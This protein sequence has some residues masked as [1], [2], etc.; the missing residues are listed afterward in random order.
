MQIKSSE[1]LSKYTGQ[2]IDDAI[3][4]MRDYDAEIALKADKSTT[5]NGQPLSEDVVLTATDVGAVPNDVDWGASLDYDRG[6]LSLMNPQGVNISSQFIWPSWGEIQGNDLSEN[7]V[8]QTALDSK[9]NEITSLSMLSSDLVDD[10]NKV[11]KFATAGQL[12]QIATNQADIV[13]INSKIPAQAT[14]SNQ[15]ADKDFVN[16]SITTNT[17][18]FIGTFQSL[19]E[20]EAYS[21]TVTNNDYG[22]VEI[23]DQAGNTFYDRYKYNSNTSS[24]LFEY[25]INNSSF[26]S[27]QWAS[28]NSNATQESIAQITTN[29]NDISTI[30]NTLSTFGNIVTHNVSEFASSAEGSLAGTALQPGDNI[31]EL[32]NDLGFI[33][34]LSSSDVTTALGYT[35]YDS[36]NPDGF[37]DSSALAHYVQDSREINGKPLSSNINLSASDVGALADSVVIPT[38]SDAYSAFSSDGMSGI[39]VASALATSGFISSISSSDVISALG[40]TP[41]D[42]TNPDGFIS[43][44]DVGD[45]TVTFT[46]GGVNKGSITMNQSGNTTISL[47]AGSQ[48][49]QDIQVLSGGAITLSRSKSIYTSSPI[50]TTTYSFDSSGLDLTSDISYTFELYVDLSFVYGLNFPASVKWQDGETPD[51]SSTGK[52]LFAFRTMDAGTTWIGNLQGR[53]V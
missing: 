52:Y 43:M 41:Y 23:H 3:G 50:G 32:T 34:S 16:S 14:S 40:Y 42:I 39:A 4:G 30:N 31:S 5:V 33:S 29:K 44:S 53:W 46:Q 21:G 48:T 25:E 49:V 38:I 35:P 24:W 13:T 36:S 12:T 28:L 11:H 17:S 45:G 47:D 8:L 1:Y 7:A 2:Q 15:L 6:Y 19:A 10:T 20:L 22:F 9:Q 51:L 26:T 27:A 37:I 18:F